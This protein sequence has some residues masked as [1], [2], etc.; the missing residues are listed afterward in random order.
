MVNAA[1]SEGP[2]GSQTKHFVE[3]HPAQMPRMAHY[4]TNAELNHSF[5]C[6]DYIRVVLTTGRRGLANAPAEPL[7]YK[8]FNN[9]INTNQP[10][11]LSLSLSTPQSIGAIEY[12]NYITAEAPNPMSVLIWH[13]TIWSWGSRQGALRNVEY[14]FIAIDPWST[15]TW[16]GSPW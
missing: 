1:W 9:V 11:S 5:Q 15:L 8:Y 12:T 6:E 16:S 4:N 2:H 7:P 13:K 10:L 14:P 3:D